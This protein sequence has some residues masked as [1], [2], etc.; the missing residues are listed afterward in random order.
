MA[1]SKGHLK[2]VKKLLKA[3]ADRGIRNS[4]SKT[5]LMV[6][7]DNEFR[8]IERVLRDERGLFDCL[9]LYLNLRQV[10]APQSR[11]I[12]KP[13]LFALLVC[14]NLCIRTLLVWQ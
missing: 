11:S 1:T 14:V 8:N 2:I 12:S 5:A 13:L 9:K 7:H 3:G 6:A 4:S 10:Y